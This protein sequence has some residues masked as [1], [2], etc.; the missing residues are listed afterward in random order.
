M[1]AASSSIVGVQHSATTLGDTYIGSA[2]PLLD[3]GIEVGDAVMVG[4]LT[5]IITEPFRLYAVSAKNGEYV[6]EDGGRLVCRP[7]YT[8]LDEDGREYFWPAHKVRLPDGSRS[9]L[10]LVRKR[11]DKAVV[12][13]PAAPAQMSWPFPIVGS[14]FM[15]APITVPGMQA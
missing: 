11:V 7:G 15:G 6:D 10:R 12:V 2:H 13:E 3:A 4:G 8:C 1:K 5:V 14:T 9:H